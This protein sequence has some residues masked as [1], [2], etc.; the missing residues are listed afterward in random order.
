[1]ALLRRFPDAIGAGVAALC[2]CALTAML[3]S[4]LVWN[5][6]YAFEIPVGGIR[7]FSLVGVLPTLHILLDLL[8]KS[9]YSPACARQNLIMLALQVAILALAV[10]VR[11]SSLPSPG[12]PRSQLR[13]RATT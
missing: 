1:V 7:Y 3:F 4:A 2:F 12:F 11:G 5:P 6:G 9:P 8:D 13:C 10:L